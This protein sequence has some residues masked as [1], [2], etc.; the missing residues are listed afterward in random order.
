LCQHQPRSTQD[1]RLILFFPLA[2]LSRLPLLVVFFQSLDGG[3]LLA[4]V[5]DHERHGEVVEAMTPGDFHD[6]VEGDE[7]VAGVEHG[8]VAFS[9]ADVDELDYC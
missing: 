8:D 7:V 5:A 6:G 9:A 4:H 3:G 2:R 1:G